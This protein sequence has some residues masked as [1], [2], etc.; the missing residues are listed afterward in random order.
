LPKSFGSA[1]IF[2]NLYLFYNLVNVMDVNIY[3]LKLKAAFG[4]L[5]KVTISARR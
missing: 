2:C 3:D 5:F 4:L 1:G